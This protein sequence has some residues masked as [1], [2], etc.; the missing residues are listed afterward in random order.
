MLTLRGSALRVTYSIRNMAETPQSF[1]YACHPL[2]AVEPGDRILLPDEVHTLRLDYSRYGRLGKVGDLIRWPRAD[3]DVQLDQVCAANAG[4]ADMLYTGRL[5]VGA[6]GI[7]RRATGQTLRVF[8]PVETLPHL[9]VWLCYGGWPDDAAEHR[10]YA[11]ALEPT[12]APWNSLAQ[13]Q[14][15]G[16]ATVLAAGAAYEFYITFKVGPSGV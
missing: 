11:V 2:F 6:C 8:F 10:Q 13:A 7:Q 1:L 5:R 3:A 14:R 9:G 15:Q 12:T 16:A 4:T